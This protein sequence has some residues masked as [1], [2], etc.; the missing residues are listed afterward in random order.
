MLGIKN[1]Q[2][3]GVAPTVPAGL[4]V[5]H[6]T[7]YSKLLYDPEKFQNYA[8]MSQPSFHELPDFIKYL[9]SGTSFQHIGYNY[10][11]SHNHTGFIVEETCRA[12]WERLKPLC[13]PIPDR[14][15]WERIADECY[16]LWNF[17]NCVGSIDETHQEI[18]CPK[19]AGSLYFN[20]KDNHSLVV[21]AVADA[22]YNFLVLDIGDYGRNSDGSVF[23]ESAFGQDFENNR[24][25]L[26]PPKAL[27]STDQELPFV[28][29]ADEAHPLRE[30]LLT[31][32]ARRS[33][34]NP[35]RI[36]IARLS[37]ARKKKLKYCSDQ[38]AVQ[39]SGPLSIII[40]ASYALH[41]FVRQH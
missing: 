16:R 7:L 28:F 39:S 22:N 2:E 33:L 15:T 23:R 34:S 21:Q 37:R 20:Y 12:I 8:R 4:R 32:Y 14:D 31:P 30:N 11:V 27:P 3:C 6:A 24:L 38:F 19:N 5:K 18:Q 41:N 9:A 25:N 36:F 26:P 40:Q 35:S 29:L 1:E 17:P 10:R 13:L